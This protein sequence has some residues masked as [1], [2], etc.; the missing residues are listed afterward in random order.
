M[1]SNLNS[2]AEARRAA[3]S[4]LFAITLA[5][6]PSTSASITGSSSAAVP[7]GRVV[8]VAAGTVSAALSS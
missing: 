8:D 3:A 6:R 1:T 5:L 2:L 7:L 4:P